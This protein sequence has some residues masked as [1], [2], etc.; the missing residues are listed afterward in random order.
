MP[1]FKS[2]ADLKFG[3][4]CRA[5]TRTAQPADLRHVRQ[6]AKCASYIVHSSSTLTIATAC[7][8]RII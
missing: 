6:A 4:V 3:F 5:L 8:A 2:K 7:P 1:E